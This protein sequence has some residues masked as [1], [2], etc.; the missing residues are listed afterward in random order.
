MVVFSGACG[1]VSLWPAERERAGVVWATVVMAGSAGE[2][3]V[4]GA[5][6]VAGRG[7]EGRGDAGPRTDLKGGVMRRLRPS[8]R[9]GGKRCYEECL[10]P[11]RLSRS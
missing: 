10:T 2:A 4:T 8:C 11:S 5:L 9:I 6:A 7:E 3:A 1:P